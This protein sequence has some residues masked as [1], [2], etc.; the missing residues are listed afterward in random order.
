MMG[1]LLKLLKSPVV[2][3]RAAIVLLAATPILWPL[4]SLTIFRD[5]PQG[6]LGLS[7]LALILTAVDIVAT[8]DVRKEQDD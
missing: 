3:F 4:T 5:E 7:W 1:R 6:V 2:R 8:T